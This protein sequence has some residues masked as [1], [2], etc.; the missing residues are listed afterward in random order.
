MTKSRSTFLGSSL[1]LVFLV[2]QVVFAAWWNPLTWN[3]FSVIESWFVFENGPSQTNVAT[4]TS[5]MPDA[6]VSA[7][8]PAGAS[9]PQNQT[10]H[11]LTATN[12][13]V[14]S[15]AAVQTGTL[16]NGVY[17]SDCPSGDE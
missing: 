6:V 11:K 16:C 4:T 8:T 2:P 3:V 9:P 14:S 13:G 17:Y 1:L 12:F 15:K 5:Q 7:T 10:T